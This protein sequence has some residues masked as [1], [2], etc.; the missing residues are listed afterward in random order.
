MIDLSKINLTKLFKMTHDGLVKLAQ[1][2]KQL[3]N[4]TVDRLYF[5]YN[6]QLK[7][8]NIDYIR[9]RITTNTSDD[10]LI[11]YIQEAYTNLTV[12][13]GG[14]LGAKEL[15]QI[16]TFNKNL[17]PD[18]KDSQYELLYNHFLDMGT[19]DQIKEVK[20]II[21]SDTAFSE[22][23]FKG[24][25]IERTNKVMKYLQDKNLIDFAVNNLL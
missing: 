20:F 5:K 11:E 17:I 8:L 3:N 25:R 10:N 13:G 7:E 21:G 22:N 18:I 6:K 2:M 19:D 24:S 16:E 14:K 15:K 1:K 9:D 4:K 12:G 23:M